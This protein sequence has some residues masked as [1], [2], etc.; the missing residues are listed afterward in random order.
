MSMRE[1]LIAVV[2]LVMMAPPTIAANANIKYA[3]ECGAARSMRLPFS[4]IR[5]RSP[6]NFALK[7]PFVQSARTTSRRPTSCSRLDASDQWPPQRQT[8]FG[9]LKNPASFFY[10]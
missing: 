3:L 1:A 4:S 7:T 5:P 2:A 9:F 8:G 10:C 6:T